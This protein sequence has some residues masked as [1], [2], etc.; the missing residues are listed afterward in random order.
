MSGGG[1]VPSEMQRL[2]EIGV[3]EPLSEPKRTRWQQSMRMRDA[4]SLKRVGVQIEFAAS[5]KGESAQ[6][7]NR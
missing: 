6:G 3:L 1:R 7:R 5:I 2:W 4:V